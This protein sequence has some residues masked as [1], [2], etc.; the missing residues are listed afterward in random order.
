MKEANAISFIVVPIIYGLFL[1]CLSLT[2]FLRKVPLPNGEGS[3][4]V[5]GLTINYQIS[6]MAIYI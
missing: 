2:H 5:R 1:A 4:L 3:E 6:Y